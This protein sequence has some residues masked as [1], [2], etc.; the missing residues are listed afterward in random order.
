ML[1]E[2]KLK[3]ID[4]LMEGNI[5]KTEIE[6]EIGVHRQTI[7][8]WLKDE[9][10]LA[11]YDRRLNDNRTKC[12]R[13]LQTWL[14]PLLHKLY[15]IAMNGATRD[16]KDAAI[17]LVNRVLGTPKETMTVD[18]ATESKVDPLAMF[19][20]IVKKTPTTEKKTVK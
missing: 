2:K 1:N 16:S 3:M 11:E 13:Q 15:F 9:E 19:E 12:N 6:K 8:D 20:E 5:E 14:D 7:Y 10:V 4:L 18:K 17:Y